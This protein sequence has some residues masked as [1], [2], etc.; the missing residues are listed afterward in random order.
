MTDKSGGG[1][2]RRGDQRGG[3]GDKEG[4][5]R[6]LSSAGR[7]RHS[8]GAIFK[9]LRATMPSTKTDTGDVSLHAMLFTQRVR[10]TIVSICHQ[11]NSLVTV[12]FASLFPL[13]L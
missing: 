10:S 9:E 11:C 4:R 5:H 8:P 7:Q 6:A 13:S 2:A 3:V 1:P 12:H